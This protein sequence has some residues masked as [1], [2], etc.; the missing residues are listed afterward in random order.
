MRWIGRAGA[1]PH[2]VQVSEFTV[3]LIACYNRAW[4]SLLS[5]LHLLDCH[6][7][8]R[9]TP[10]GRP[11]N[12]HTHQAHGLSRAL[13]D[14]SAAGHLQLNSTITRSQPQQPCL[15][16]NS[17]RTTQPVHPRHSL[18]LDSRFIHTG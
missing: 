5:H 8:S 12:L 9:K 14:M 10:A 17:A 2:S 11:K 4:H 3:I 1:R 16:A 6:S 15:P 18:V 13:C 7:I